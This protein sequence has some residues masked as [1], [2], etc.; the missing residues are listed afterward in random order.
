MDS[1]FNTF[2]NITEPRPTLPSLRS[3]NLPIPRISKGR[4][5]TTSTNT[6]PINDFNEL[7]YATNNAPHWAKMRSTS[8]SSARSTSS[9]TSNSFNSRTPSPTP[10]ETSL[11]STSSTRSNGSFRLVPCD[12]ENADA[13]VLVTEP[14]DGSSRGK[15]T[16]LVG[17]AAQPYRQP[18]TRPVAKGARVHPYKITSSQG[19]S[20]RSS[21]LSINSRLD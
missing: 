17:T 15:A 13:V 21:M 12:L 7:A 1:F 11:A 2:T 4:A 16:L 9:S 18:S 10:S 6:S 3:L 5:D 20:R 14:T 19:L 8:N